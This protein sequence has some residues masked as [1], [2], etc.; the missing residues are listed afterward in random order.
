MVLNIHLVSWD[1]ISQLHPLPIS[2]APQATCWQGSV[3]SRK[4]LD[5]VQA[6]LSSQH[7][8]A[9][10]TVFSTISKHSPMRATTEKMNA[11]PAETSANIYVLNLFCHFETV[12]LKN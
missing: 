8:C 1:H 12:S 4:G 6:L 2:Y 5:I 7:P 10:N 9:T 3:R 11:I